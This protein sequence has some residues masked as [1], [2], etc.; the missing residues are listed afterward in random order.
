[1]ANFANAKQSLSNDISDLNKK[2][3]LF[4][5]KQIK[6]EKN[7]KCLKQYGCRENLEIH[8]IPFTQNENTN[9]M[10]KKVANVLK[11]KLE[12]KDIL[13]SHRIF[14]DSK[15]SSKFGQFE[16]RNNSKH[17]PIILRF[18][19]RDKRNKI[20]LNPLKNNAVG[21][22]TRNPTTNSIPFNFTVLWAE[23]LRNIF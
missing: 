16:I 21:P 20:F 5:K 8:G 11:V 7:L 10:V 1:M 3:G 2:I 23:N 17:P 14:N 18:T 9:K 15:L 12:D 6:T 19:D 22:N 4:N 13:T